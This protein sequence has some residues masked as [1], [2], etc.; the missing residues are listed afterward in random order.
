MPAVISTYNDRGDAT[1]ASQANTVS[2]GY[3]FGAGTEASLA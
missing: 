1:A 2:L 3:E